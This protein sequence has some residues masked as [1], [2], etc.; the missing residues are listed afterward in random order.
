MGAPKGNKNAA[1]PH[2]GLDVGGFLGGF[3]DA[4]MQ[5]HQSLYKENPKGYEKLVKQQYRLSDADWKM[6]KKKMNLK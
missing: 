1:G 6:Y 3:A 4:A 2:D 5:M